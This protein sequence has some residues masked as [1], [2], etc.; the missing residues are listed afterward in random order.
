MSK[1]DEVFKNMKNGKWT[2][3]PPPPP[4]EPPRGPRTFGYFRVSTARQAEEGYSLDGQKAA[5][6]KYARDKGIDPVLFFVDP[7]V[8][9]SKVPLA[10]R[11]AGGELVRRLRPGDR[12]VVPKIDRGF[13]NFSDFVHWHDR[14]TEAGIGLHIVN[15]IGAQMDS[16]TAMGRMMVRQLALFAAWE[17]E[18][19]RERV[20]EAQAAKLARGLLLTRRAPKGFK[21]VKQG[22]GWR[23]VPDPAARRVMGQM[24]GWVEEGQA[25]RDI[26]AH[27]NEH[28]VAIGERKTWDEGGVFR[29]VAAEKKLRKAE[30]KG[31]T[32]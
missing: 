27:L 9:A 26:A 4:P 10:D 5:I 17:S 29:W 3:P 31:V 8:S 19:N 7:G 21:A 24:L 16:S 11:E 14:W 6:E 23:A 30:K 12:V 28:G 22:N 25:Y 32:A 2:A 13:R 20:M 15:F 18:C 1:F